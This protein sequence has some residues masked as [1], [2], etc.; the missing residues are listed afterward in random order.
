MAELS[1]QV[2]SAHG[3]LQKEMV[4][5]VYKRAVY[6]LRDQ[7]RIELQAVSPLV[8]AQRNEDIA[9]HVNYAQMLG[10]LFGG[11]DIQNML[12]PQKFAEKLAYWYE[13][14]NDLLTSE[15]EQRS[16]VQNLMQ[17]AGGASEAGVDP[18]SAAQTLLP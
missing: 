11:A 9:Q 14:D 17:L 18:V 2:G 6:L 1:R 5:P 12:N 16:N 13:I 8:R 10:Q 15:D 7:G 4:F 3:R